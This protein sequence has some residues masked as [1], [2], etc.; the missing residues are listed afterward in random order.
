MFCWVDWT[1]LLNTVC[2]F[3]CLPDACGLFLFLLPEARQKP[4][5][6]LSVCSSLLLFSSSDHPF[7]CPAFGLSHIFGRLV[8]DTD[9]I[10][11]IHILY[12]RRFSSDCISGSSLPAQLPELFAVSAVQC[13][14]LFTRQ[15]ISI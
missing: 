11:E 5:F 12:I 2:F 6:L 7:K 3:S 13:N 15:G 1:G 4:S 14:D 8:D 9:I 10:L